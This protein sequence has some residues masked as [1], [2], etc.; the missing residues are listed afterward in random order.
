M[1]VTYFSLRIF[2]SGSKQHKTVS[3]TPPYTWSSVF[4]G[5]EVAVLIA[6]KGFFLIILSYHPTTPPKFHVCP[7]VYK[8]TS[9]Y[10]P[11]QNILCT[12]KEMKNDDDDQTVIRG[13]EK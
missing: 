4:P 12:I 8:V 3:D 1:N 10:T 2:G 13:D 7:Y 6:S 11:G 5:G 9:H